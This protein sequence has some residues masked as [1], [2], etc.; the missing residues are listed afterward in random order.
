MDFSRQEYWSWL[1]LPPPGDLPILGIEPV[2]LRYSTLASGVFFSFITSATG[3]APKFSMCPEV[4]T[5][6]L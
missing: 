6:L 5:H 4:E 3:E 1:P 2:S